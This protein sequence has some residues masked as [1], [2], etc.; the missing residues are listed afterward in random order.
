MSLKDDA[1]ALGI[2]VDGRW[3]DTRI[4]EEI[5]KVLAAKPEPEP[6]PESN[7]GSLPA[8]EPRK[9]ACIIVRDFWDES[10]VRQPAGKKIEVSVDAALDGIESGALMRD[11]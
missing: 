8:P 3:S 4:Q 2:K 10:G 5:D 7:E 9:I 11:R 6:E 1:E